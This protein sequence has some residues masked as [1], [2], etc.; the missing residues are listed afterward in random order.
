MF[1]VPLVIR[2]VQR[3]SQQALLFVLCVALSL[4]SLTAFSGFSNSVGRSLLND[5]RT[6]H[7]AD[8]IIK[9]YDPI[10]P[11]LNNAVDQLVAAQ[12]LQRTHL[13]VFLSVVRRV[14]E[15]SSVLAGL[16][17]VEEGYPFYGEVA[18]ASGREFTDQARAR[19]LL[20]RLD[21]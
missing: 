18:L 14:D 17:V 12:Q 21:P 15:R 11:T 5:A 7:A 20:D 9:S 13:H 16:K 8:I 2:Q 3:S 6:L 10:S 1:Q 19:D 4:T